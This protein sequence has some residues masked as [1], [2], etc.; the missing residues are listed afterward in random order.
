MNSKAS[1][2]LTKIVYHITGVVNVKKKPF[3]RQRS[4]YIIM[5]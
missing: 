3:E 1:L 4:L 5:L 2:S